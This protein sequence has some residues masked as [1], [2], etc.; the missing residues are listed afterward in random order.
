M[1]PP[2]EAREPDGRCAGGRVPPAP[3]LPE[4]GI[5]AA[6]AVLIVA[7]YIAVQL[8]V[9]V[10]VGLVAG[11]YYGAT[12]GATTGAVLA[13]M[14]RVVALPAA[15][16]GLVAG[17]IAA[18]LMTRR[19]LPGP[20]RGGSL[21][22]V[23]WCAAGR[24]GVAR[25]ACAGLLIAALY[26]LVLRR[27]FPPAPGQEWGPVARTV[28]AGGW[29]RDLWAVVALFIAPPVEEFVFRGV[30]WTG[31]ARG[32]KAGLAA[33]AVTLLFLLCH[34]TELRGYWPA[35]LAISAVGLAALSLRVRAGS[36]APPVALHASYN[37]FLVAVI[38]LGSA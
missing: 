12:R 9:G 30:L 25:A 28:S 32:M 14:T 7:A 37:A 5:G 10:F 27:F 22:P 34:V 11:V 17:G 6:R 31:L 29:Q 18:F 16:L 21:R 4:A 13:E 20:V 33:A 23:G 35:W 26:V 24:G 15:A 19:A 8:A 2:G 38:Y 36:L 1:E 3:P